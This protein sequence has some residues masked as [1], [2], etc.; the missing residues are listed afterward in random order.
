MTGPHLQLLNHA[1]KRGNSTG[2]GLNY[3]VSP[4]HLCPQEDA[5]LHPENEGLRNSVSDNL[6]AIIDGEMEMMKKANDA[7]ITPERLL[8]VNASFSGKYPWGFEYARGQNPH[9]A[10]FQPQKVYHGAYKC[11]P[12]KLTTPDTAEFDPHSYDTDL[13]ALRQGS[14]DFNEWSDDAAKG[15]VQFKDDIFS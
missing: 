6:L 7:K 8:M 13:A 10:P 9:A 5:E 1:A 12:V 14:E 4:P 11:D 3:T 15:K 2:S